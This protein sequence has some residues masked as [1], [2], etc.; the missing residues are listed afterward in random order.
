MYANPVLKPPPIESKL[1]RE[2]LVLCT[3]ESPFVAPTGDL[4]LQ[5]DG[6]AM[7]SPLGPIFAEFY[8]AN[9]E[10]QLNLLI[11][12]KTLIYWLMTFLS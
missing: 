4:F 1:L 6:V 7:G 9:I 12:S 2:A 5:I 3:T 11:A 10:K 8:M